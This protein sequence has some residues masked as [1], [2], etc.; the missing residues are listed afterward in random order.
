MKNKTYQSIA[1][2]LDIIARAYENI[3]S[4]GEIKQG[5]I[6]GAEIRIKSAMDSAPHGSGI[7]SGI[8]LDD[9]STAQK[10]VFTFGFHHMNENGMYDGW[11]QHKAIITPDLQFGYRLKIT[12]RDRNQIKEYLYEIISF[13]LDSDLPV[14]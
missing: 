2:Q 8:Q 12:G 4:T 1:A 14:A 10:L 6:D 9:S 5:W 7:D 3:N 13:W 11:T